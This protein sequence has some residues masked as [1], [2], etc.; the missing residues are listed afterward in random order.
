[1]LGERDKCVVKEQVYRKDSGVLGEGP[2]VTKEQV[3]T[4]ELDMLRKG[5][6]HKGKTSCLEEG[7][8]VLGKRTWMVK[9]QV[10]RKVSGVLGEEKIYRCGESEVSGQVWKRIA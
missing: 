3:C 2:C 5:T 10:Y 6:C 8:C 9:E 4:G 7:S 1:M